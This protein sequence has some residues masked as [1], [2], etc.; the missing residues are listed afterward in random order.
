MKNKLFISTLVSYLGIYITMPVLSAISTKAHLIP[1]QIGIMISCGAFAMLLFAPLWGKI[2]DRFGRRIVIIIGMLGMGLFFILYVFLFHLSISMSKTL[3]YMVY[4]LIA[5]R[6]LLGIFM[7]TTPTA[8]SAYMA[9]ISAP[10]DRAKDMASLGF[11]TGLAMVLGP[12]IGGAV[13]AVGNLYTPFYLT[14]VGLLVFSVVMGFALP[15]KAETG[16]SKKKEDFAAASKT[17]MNGFFSFELFGWLIAGCSVMFIVVVL[18]LVTSLYLHDGFK[19]TVNQSAQTAS[20]LF[21]VLGI[22]LMAVQVLQ[23]KVLQWTAKKMMIVGIPLIIGGML[24]ATINSW[25]Y[26]IFVSYILIGAGAGLGMSSLSAGCSLAVSENQQGAVAGTVAMIQGIAGIVSPLV[27]S[28]IYQL[29]P[30]LPFLLFS[31]FS[32]FAYLM[33]LVATRRKKVSAV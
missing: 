10:Q 6:F 14:I 33:F 27:G 18:Q 20:L 16:L 24:L 7:T 30:K 22:A 4:A 15:R 32:L 9:D 19:Q 28:W 13:S 31:C 21:F 11:A 25:Y 23:M 12:M 5:T 3:N 26:L 1:S 29:D 2:S 17:K 8:A